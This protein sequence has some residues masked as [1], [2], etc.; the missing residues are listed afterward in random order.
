MTK[1]VET[2]YGVARGE[3]ILSGDFT[4]VEPAKTELTHFEEQ[5]RVVGL[6]PDVRLVQYD[7]TTTTSRVRAYREPVEGE[8]ADTEGD[9]ASGEAGDTAGDAAP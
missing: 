2:K 5:M 1:N 3:K 4:N 7:V 6:E 8:E 9:D